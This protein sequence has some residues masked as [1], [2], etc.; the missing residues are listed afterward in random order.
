MKNKKV[1]ISILF[2]TIIILIMVFSII[3]PTFYLFQNGLDDPEWDGIV[4]N[5]F[6]SGTGTQEDPYIISTPNE[7]A[8]F[9]LSMENDN[10]E[11]KYIKLTKDIIINK[12]VFKDNT[13]IY[14]NKEYYLKDNGK[15]YLDKDF[16]TEINDV[17]IMP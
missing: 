9:A 7:L 2:S 5:S 16:N 8:Y 6:N 12:G 14:N 10:Y 4:D 13:Y 3:I 1:L 15:Y 17:N 11:G